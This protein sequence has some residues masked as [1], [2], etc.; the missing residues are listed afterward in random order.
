MDNYMDFNGMTD[1]E[2][3]R[4][5]KMGHTEGI[6]YLLNKYKGSV[7][8]KAHSFYLMG[9]D[10]DDLIQEGMIGLMRA[11]HNFDPERERSFAVFAELCISRRIYSAV[12]ASQR[13]KHQPLN[14]YVSLYQQEDDDENAPALVDIL[15]QTE[16]G[17]EDSYFLKESN[18]RLLSE[19]RGVLSPLERKVLDLF[20]DGTS[21]AQIAEQLNKDEK[22]VDNALQ[23]IRT[24]AYRLTHISPG[25]S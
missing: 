1:E 21:Y 20:M 25:D 9:G 13:K 5:I 11:V 18:M 12:R 4:H 16:Q 15:A 17:P 2:I 8:K 14:S 24:K 22:S 23:R 3:C 19:L 6:D 7:R 10:R